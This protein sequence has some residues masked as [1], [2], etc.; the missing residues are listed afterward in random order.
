LIFCIMIRN[1]N[2][3]DK[4]DK[5]D[6]L[7][8]VAAIIFFNRS[9]IFM[10]NY[11]GAWKNGSIFFFNINMALIVLHMTYLCDILAGCSRNVRVIYNFLF[12]FN[13]NFL[14]FLIFY[15]YIIFIFFFL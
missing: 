7:V 2:K 14:L 10:G 8:E 9:N 1:S 15:F 13:F 5:S 3:I 6:F 11:Y 4:I 12:F